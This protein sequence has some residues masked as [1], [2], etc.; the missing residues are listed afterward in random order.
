[1]IGPGSSKNRTG[2]IPSSVVLALIFQ[3]TTT[4]RRPCTKRELPWGAPYCGSGGV[5]P[6]VGHMR[7]PALEN[8]P[9]C[10]GGAHAVPTNPDAHQSASG[11]KGGRFGGACPECGPN[12]AEGGSGRGENQFPAPRMVQRVYLMRPVEHRDVA[13]SFPDRLVSCDLLHLESVEGS[14]NAVLS[15]VIRRALLGKIVEDI[16]RQPRR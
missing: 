4:H 1:M 6:R 14:R 11:G 9:R 15:D 7:I 3:A 10:S 13:T 5:T 8:V 12:N 2:C 16:L